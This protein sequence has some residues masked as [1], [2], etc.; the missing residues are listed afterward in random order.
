MEAGVVIAVLELSDVWEEQDDM[1]N[2]QISSVPI[3]GIKLH[4]GRTLDPDAGTMHRHIGIYSVGS[5]MVD[6]RISSLNDQT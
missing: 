6:P 5:V 2:S 1:G 4:V 3:K